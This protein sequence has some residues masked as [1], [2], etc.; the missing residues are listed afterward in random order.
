MLL[1]DLRG[2]AFFY[3]PP[4]KYKLN[5]PLLGP[6]ALVTDWPG[7]SALENPMVRLSILAG[8]VVF[9][10]LLFSKYHRCTYD[11]LF[12]KDIENLN[13]TGVWEMQILLVHSVFVDHKSTL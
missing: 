10:S 5:C 6:R 9:V 1:P 12:L 7:I 2:Y 3:M 11:W 13:C 8:C 4:P